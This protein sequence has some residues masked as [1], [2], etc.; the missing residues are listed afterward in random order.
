M[1]H[2][3]KAITTGY[4]GFNIIKREWVNCLYCFCFWTEHWIK[5]Y[6]NTVLNCRCYLEF[7]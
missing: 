1:L 5:E 3:E 6:W 2:T 4:I 7:S